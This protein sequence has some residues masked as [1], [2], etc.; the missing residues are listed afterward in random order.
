MKAKPSLRERFRYW[1][2]NRF[3]GGPKVIIS[4]LVVVTLL[5]VGV[6]TSIAL[7]PGIHPEGQTLKEVFWNILFQALTPNPFDTTVRWEFLV[8]MLVVT[9]GSL[10]MVSILIGTLTSGI[11]AKM[12]ELRK[13][14]SRVLENDHIL[15]LGWSSQIFTILSELM[16]AFEHH[17]NAHIV[18]LAD[19]DKVEMEEEIHARV[20]TTGSTHIICRNGNPIDMSDL[21]IANPHTA[22][23]III[24]PPKSDNPDSVVIKTILAL[25]NNPNRRQGPYHIVTQIREPKNM[26]VVKLVG[27]RDSVQPVLINDLIARVVAQTSR[28]SGLSV[29]YTELLNFEGDEIYFQEEP[30]L[31]GKTFGETLLAYETSAVM[32]LRFADGRIALNPPMDTVL[33]PGDQVIAISEDDDTVLLSGLTSVPL[34][35][36]AIHQN[37]QERQPVPKRSLI[38]G[39]NRS[40]SKIIQELDAY[41]AK[42]SRLTVVADPHVSEQVAQVENEIKACARALKNQKLTFE[43]GDTTDRALLDQLKL[44]DYDHVIALSYAGLEVQE[45]DARTLVTLLH[46]RDIAER[47]ETPF[48]IVSEMLDLRNREL[49]EVAHVDDFIVSDH[50]VSLMMAQLSENGDLYGVFANIFDPEGSE[51]YLKPI[52]DYI[53]AGEPVNFYTVVEAARPRGEVAIGYRLMSEAG[54]AAKSYGVHTNPKKSELVAFAPEDKIIVV[55]EN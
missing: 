39:W 52:G 44:M 9:L 10:L 45:A 42:G 49:A 29:V 4:W 31:T 12:D 16:T 48:S 17:K 51:I 55:A 37:G 11:E 18:I 47:D 41:V 54:E 15:I 50:L 26:E 40:G 20:K 8:V 14:R 25:T 35:K 38:L 3:S 1:F 21:E 30:G 34:D 28:Q 43:Q 24:L 5:L 22:R 7:I 6:M 23:A 46:L 36:S 32:G 13:G 19:H 33:K 53:E 27:V 2:D